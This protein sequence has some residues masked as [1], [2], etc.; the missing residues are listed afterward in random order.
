VSYVVWYICMAYV[1]YRILPSSIYRSSGGLTL[2]GVLIFAVYI[3][4]K[5]I[6]RM[7]FFKT[8][9]V[10]RETI[11]TILI[12]F[13]IAFIYFIFIILITKGVNIAI[14]Q[15]SA[16][17]N[18]P[19][20]YTFAVCFLL[21][22]LIV[23]LLEEIYWRGYVY[24]A[25]ESKVGIVAAVAIIALFEVWLHVAQKEATLIYFIT[26]FLGSAVRT[27]MRAKFNSLTPC[28]VYHYT[29]NSLCFIFAL[30]AFS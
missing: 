19:D 18:I 8:V 15:P 5:C 25:L 27:V 20:I 21:A 7:P 24:P 30:K 14:V 12:A 2:F 11:Q 17:K 9:K 22:S 6:R 4:I 29:Y 26:I 23:P 28:I 10:T 3:S 1:L 13:S 16:L